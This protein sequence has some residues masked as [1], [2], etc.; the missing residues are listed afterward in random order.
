M[1]R[2]QKTKNTAKKGLATLAAASTLA[3]AAP[4]Q[5]NAQ[6]SCELQPTTLT[7]QQAGKIQP[8]EV[9]LHNEEL[10]IDEAYWLR[11]PQAGDE[12]TSELADA[13]TGQWQLFN[14]EGKLA[15]AIAH[16]N[17]TIKV[18]SEQ[19][20]LRLDA[21]QAYNAQPVTHNNKPGIAFNAQDAY[22][23]ATDQDR[24][25]TP[26][27]IQARLYCVQECD[28]PTQVASGKANI[29]ALDTRAQPE[30]QQ[31][32]K[33][34]NYLHDLLD[35][36]QTTQEP[37]QPR[38]KKPA[39][40]K[41]HADAKTTLQ[42][43]AGYNALQGSIEN[44]FGN[45]FVEVPIDGQ[46]VNGQAQL[47]H[48]RDNA[49][50]RLTASYTQ[51]Q[52]TDDYSEYTREGFGIADHIDSD[53]RRIDLQGQAAVNVLNGF[54]LGVQGH[55]LSTTHTDQAGTFSRT[56]EETYHVTPSAGI[57]S[58]NLQFL[59]GPSFGTSTRRHATS[60]GEE[61]A[62]LGDKPAGV[63]ATLHADTQL[64]KDWNL[65]LQSRFEHGTYRGQAGADDLQRTHLEL[66]AG[67]EKALGRGF[68]AHLGVQ[69][70]FNRDER[71]NYVQSTRALQPT[72]GLKKEF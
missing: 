57:I 39:A 67:V 7:T 23:A 40:T 17:T 26:L 60:F 11:T 68:G 24:P 47:A 27:T 13:Y 21:P 9:H 63:A 56:G 28:Q 15:A 31:L 30:H 19:E 61:H 2:W 36:E 12:L 34:N 72:I 14:E 22:H 49:F 52:R 51:G 20:N 35:Q 64:P 46:A 44:E 41:E 69:A 8:L 10:N 45:R 18:L 37:A 42:L 29:F 4:T 1:N 48:T 33:E 32:I 5:S 54:A 53:V 71:S 62:R 65:N 3:L 55:Y 59:A 16:P 70:N 6:T 66:K 50:A 43:N 38:T 58:K 25:I